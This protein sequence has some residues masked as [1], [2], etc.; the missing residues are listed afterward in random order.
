MA[1]IKILGSPRK[2]ISP[3]ILAHFKEKGRK[4]ENWIHRAQDRDNWLCLPQVA[5]NHRVLQKAG[6]FFIS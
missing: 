3:P 2:L 5:M 1:P 4:R 6:N